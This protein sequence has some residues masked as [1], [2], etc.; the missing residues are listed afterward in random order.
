[1]VR[2]KWFTVD[3]AK[4]LSVGH[5]KG[6]VVGQI[7][8][9]VKTNQY[10]SVQDVYCGSDQEAGL[11]ISSTDSRW[12]RTEINSGGSPWIKKLTVGQVKRLTV[13]EV[14]IRSRGSLWVRSRG[15]L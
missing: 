5:V 8:M 12:V 13:D 4:K 7:N 2:A 9:W 3:R 10:G 6:L 14:K 11:W 15:P 1:M